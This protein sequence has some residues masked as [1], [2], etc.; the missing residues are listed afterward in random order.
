MSFPHGVMVTLRTVNADTDELG[1]G[2]TDP[3]ERRWGPCA[4]WDRFATEGTDPHAPAVIIGKNF[5]GPRRT[6]RSDDQIVYG[7]YV[8]EVDG[9]PQDSTVNPFTGWDPGIVV[10]TKRGAAV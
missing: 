5:A 4:V 6:I 3:S 2:E 8:W 9:P 1:D 7:G 10:A